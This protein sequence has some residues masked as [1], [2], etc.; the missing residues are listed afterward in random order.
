M[1]QVRHPTLEVSGI[2]IHT[3]DGFGDQKPQMLGNSL[4]HEGKV[5]GRQVASVAISQV[6][7]CCKVGPGSS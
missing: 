1:I 7:G 2:K 3:R 5:G 6:Q 4:D